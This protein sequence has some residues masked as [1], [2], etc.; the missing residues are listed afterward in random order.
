MTLKVSAEQELYMGRSASSLATV[1]LSCSERIANVWNSA[2]TRWSLLKK[3]D[4]STIR[5]PVQC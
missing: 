5:R 1:W 4:F 2:S 3:V